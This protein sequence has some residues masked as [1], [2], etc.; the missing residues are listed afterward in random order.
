MVNYT[1]ILFKVFFI[2]LINNLSFSYEAKKILDNINLKILPNTLNVLI[3]S[4][5]SGKST[6]FML[7]SKLYNVDN[8]MIYYNDVDINHYTSCY[9]I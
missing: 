8:G 5:G 7:L 4:S 3:G 9:H 6:L 2:Y 1:N